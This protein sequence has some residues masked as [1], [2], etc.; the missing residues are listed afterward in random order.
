MKK[1]ILLLLLIV[2]LINCSKGDSDSTDEENN[3]NSN[4]IVDSC[5]VE[6]VT[7]V[8]GNVYEVVSI[9]SQCW[10]KQNYR[11]TKYQNGDFI[12]SGEN[13]TNQF[14]AN[15]ISL[16]EN[17]A[18]CI[19]NNDRSKLNN[20]GLLYNGLVLIDPRGISVPDGWRLPEKNDWEKLF[21]E[22]GGS[23]IAGMHMKIKSADNFDNKGT[24]S[25]GFSAFASGHRLGYMGDIRNGSFAAEGVFARFWVAKTSFH[26]IHLGNSNDKAFYSG[27]GVFDGTASIR[28]I[29][30]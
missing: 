17:D 18:Y 25:S 22:L 2:P 21:D 26:S 7:D 8:D 28:L 30:N 23:E 27:G 9:G 6:S 24:N 5:K 1:L 29:K 16:N 11:V 3:P 14:W 13:V 15:N 19:Y 12:P 20:Y 4:L 10:L